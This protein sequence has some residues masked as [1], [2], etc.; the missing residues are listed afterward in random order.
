MKY[1]LF[2]DKNDFFEVFQASTHK[3]ECS[4]NKDKN[5]CDCGLWGSLSGIESHVNYKNERKVK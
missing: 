5:N 3:K 2:I 1:G 4:R